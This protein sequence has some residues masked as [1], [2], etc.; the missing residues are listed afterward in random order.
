M[1]PETQQWVDD[2]DY[3]LQSAK[4]MLDGGRYFFVVFMCHLA[5]E[6]LLKAVIIER[7]GV[8]PPK[9]HSLVDLASRVGLVVPT[10]HRPHIDKLNSMSVPTRYPDGRRA[11]AGALTDQSTAALYQRTLETQNG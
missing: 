3:D 6:K 1:R 5:I 10:Q 2:A 11:I 4:V 8:M 7:Q 9:V